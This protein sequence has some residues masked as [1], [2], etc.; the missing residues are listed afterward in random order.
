M[1][2]E[3]LGKTLIA[4]SI[5]SLIFSISISSYTIINLNNVYEKANPIFEKIDAIKDH[6][7]TI[8]GSLDEFSLYLKDI[9]T[10]DYMQRLSN[11][12]SFVSTL[13]SLGLGG[14]V[15][16]LS[17]DID[18]FGKMTEN[19]EEV[20]TD[21]QFARNDFSDIKYS[22]TEYDNVKQSII[23]FTRTLRIY[24]IGMMIYSII[25]NGLLLYAGYYLLKL[26]E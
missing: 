5:I 4:V 19:L 16:G 21:I 12:K 3:M 24:I 20:K 23:G 7:D 18:K 14:L 9:D 13:N 22:L 10:K 1:N 11:M 17:E 6:I 8:E 2:K 15:S 26:K 25:I